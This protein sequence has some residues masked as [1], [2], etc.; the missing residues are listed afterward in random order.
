MVKYMA[1]KYKEYLAWLKAFRIKE[2]KIQ[3]EFKTGV[4]ALADEMVRRH[5]EHLAKH[6]EFEK[7]LGKEI[8]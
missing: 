4:K 1:K 7:K 5:K 6:A 2:A 3:K 8:E